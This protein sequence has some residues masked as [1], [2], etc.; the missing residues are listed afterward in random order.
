VRVLGPRPLEPG[1]TGAVRLHLP[2]PLPLLPGDRYVLREHGRAETVGGGEVLDV[3]PVRPAARARPDRSVARVVAERGWVDADTLDRLTGTRVAPSVGRWVVDPEV[4]TAA[5]DELARRVRDAGD[6]GLDVATLGEHERAVLDRLDD[7]VVDAGRARPAGRRDPLAGHPWLAALRAEP[8]APPPP[9]G[10]DPVEVRELVRRGLVVRVDG[11]CFASSALDA[12]A[13]IV[14]RL[15]A[16]RPE[17]V[18]VAEV[19]DALGTTRKHALPLLGR[20]DA[21]GVTRRRGDRRVAGPRLPPA[22]TT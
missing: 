6:L 14:A 10:V 16:D 13:G 22:A 21:T 7:V 1:E 9:D 18:T 19:R 12:A 4:L 15:L 2:V 3:D 8:F 17:G 11:L 5:T 20:L